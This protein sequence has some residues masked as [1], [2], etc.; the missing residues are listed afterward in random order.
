MTEDFRQTLFCIS[1][2]NEKLILV[3]FI[4]V[5]I[6]DRK[7]N[8]ATKLNKY[9]S[10]ILISNTG[11]GDDTTAGRFAKTLQQIGKRKFFV[12]CAYNERT[13]H[14]LRVFFDNH[15]KCTS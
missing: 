8:L 6:H 10:S 4:H 14:F 1:S 13:L 7:H 12:D 15:R 5:W 11:I 3:N 2:S 9:E